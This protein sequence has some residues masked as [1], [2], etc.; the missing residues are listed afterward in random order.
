MSSHKYSKN[1]FEHRTIIGFVVILFIIFTTVIAD[2]DTLTWTNNGGIG[3]G[4]WHAA[5]NW[6]PTQ[7]PTDGDDV[8]IPVGT[9]PVTYSTTTTNLYSLTCSGVLTIS[10][11]ILNLLSASS[12]DTNGTLN[13]SGGSSF[14]TSSAIT[15]SGTF[16][17]SGAPLQVAAA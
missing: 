10:G 16:N 2:A 15:L 12:I 6:N 14:G 4:S 5:T 9:D 7:V 13:L 8:I 3:N 1:P 11:G 17:W